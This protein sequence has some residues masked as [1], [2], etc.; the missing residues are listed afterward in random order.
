MDRIVQN[1][2][3]QFLFCFACP[4]ARMSN[5][6]GGRSRINQTFFKLI[7]FFFLQVPK[8]NPIE[9]WKLIINRMKPD[10]TLTQMTV[11]LGPVI[12]DPHAPI[13]RH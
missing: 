8:P 4:S 10:L 5:P 3:W 9:K 11:L 2:T 13:C 1:Q 7:T 12:S 6:V